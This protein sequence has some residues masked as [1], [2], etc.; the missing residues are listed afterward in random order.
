MCFAGGDQQ[1]NYLVNQKRGDQ[2][3]HRPVPLPRQ[4]HSAKNIQQF[5]SNYIEQYCNGI[6]PFRI[7]G[8][9]RAERFDAAGPDAA[10]APRLHPQS[11]QLH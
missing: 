4:P 3:C 7:P 11:Y 6:E 9:G 1:H 2:R 5:I 10:P 8:V